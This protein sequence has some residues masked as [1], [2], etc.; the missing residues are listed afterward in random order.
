MS[1]DTARVVTACPSCDSTDIWRRTFAAN[2]QLTGVDPTYRC[3]DC[4]AEFDDPVEREVERSGTDYNITAG[5]APVASALD[6]MSPDDLGGG[7]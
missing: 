1:E 7:E 5:N 4:G 6:E 3:K 2:S